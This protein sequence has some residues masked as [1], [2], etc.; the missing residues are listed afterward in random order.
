MPAPGI[1]REIVRPNPRFSMLPD[2]PGTLAGEFRHRLL[3]VVA[4]E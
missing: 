3:D 4:D 2:K 1:S